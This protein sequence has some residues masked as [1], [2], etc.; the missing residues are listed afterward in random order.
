MSVSSRIYTA[1]QPRLSER[2]LR[3]L[4]GL[5]YRWTCGSDLTKLARSWGSDKEGY[6]HYTRH[7]QFHFRLLRATRLNLLEIGIGGYAR[8]HEGGESLRMWKSYFPKGRIYGIDIHD[9]SPHEEDRIRTFQGSQADRQFLERTVNDIG[10]LDIIIDDGSHYN[11]HVIQTF[12]ILFPLL[13]PEGIYVIEDLQTS[14]W[15]GEIVGE[16]WGGS[17]DLQATH[18]SMGFL[19]ALVDGLNYEEYDLDTY[20]PTY[21]DKHIVGMHFYHN[22]AFIYKGQNEEGSNVLGKRW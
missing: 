4:R 3:R 20:A 15:G 19:K 2:H 1:L 8:P 22:I 13:S 12:R 6:H 9:K 16:Y 17:R 5:K 10:P 14:Y 11:E 21:F 7:Y 18:T